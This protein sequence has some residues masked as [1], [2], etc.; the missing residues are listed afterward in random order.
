MRLVREI[1]FPI[2]SSGF[3]IFYFCLYHKELTLLLTYYGKLSKTPLA[4]RQKN[5]KIALLLLDRKK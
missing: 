5:T 3:D 4:I 1:G 2:I